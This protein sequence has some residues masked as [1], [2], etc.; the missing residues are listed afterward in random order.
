MS[1]NTT[2]T[3]DGD[4]LVQQVMDRLKRESVDGRQV[5]SKKGLF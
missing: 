4:K 5:I 2:Q 3:V 1:V